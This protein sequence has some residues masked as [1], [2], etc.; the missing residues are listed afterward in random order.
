MIFKIK[1][2]YF[3][4]FTFYF[5]P[6][7]Q[8]DTD[9]EDKFNGTQIYVDTISNV[10]VIEYENK[11]EYKINDS[12]TIP[13]IIQPSLGYIFPSHYNIDRD[14]LHKDKYWTPTGSDI[15]VAEKLMIEYIENENRRM[16]CNDPRYCIVEIKNFIRQY[17]GIMN[18]Q[19]EKIVCV[20]GF[21][22]SPLSAF[23]KYL[24]ED[25]I[26][27]KNESRRKGC[28]FNIKINLEKEYCFDFRINSTW[29]VKSTASKN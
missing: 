10:T 14:P 20:N 27:V 28:Y 8:S 19:K 6:G 13:I 5:L 29:R 3:L 16:N 1:S 25:I 4:I 15:N 17:F 23:A 9:T 26:L 18:Q 7:C 2:F 21:C 11:M 22:H 24:K 12:T